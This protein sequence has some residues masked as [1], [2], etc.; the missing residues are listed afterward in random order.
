MPQGLRQS[1]W[2]EI[3]TPVDLGVIK[4]FAGG[5]K[6]L[7]RM[8]VTEFA[9]S[10]RILPTE[11]SEGGRYR[12]G[13][14][15][16]MREIMDVLSPSDPTNLVVFMKPGQV[17][18][19]EGG[20]NWIGY[21]I[22]HAPGRILQV[23]PTELLAK[24]HNHTRIRPLLERTPCLRELVSKKRSRDSANTILYKEFTGGALVLAGAN[25]ASGLRSIAAQY[26]MLDEIDGYPV[27][28]DNEGDP[29]ALA[30][31]RGE[32][33]TF[34]RKGFYL[35]TPT[36]ELTSR[37]HPLYQASDRR[38]FF[39]PCPYCQHSQV[40]MWAQ[41]RWPKNEPYNAWYECE[42]CGGQWQDWQRIAATQKG[43][44]RAERERLEGMAAGFWINAIY[45]HWV[46][47]GQMA[48]RFVKVKD[49][50]VQLK[51]FVNTEL[52][53]VWNERLAMKL[54]DPKKLILRCEDYGAQVPEGVNILTIGI[55]V[56]DD[57][58]EME[59][60]GW[61]VKEESWSITYHVLMGDPSGPAI[62]EDLD[63]YL[64]QAFTNNEGR[65]YM[66]QAGCIDTGGHHTNSVYA[67]C[68]RSYRRRIWAT[69]GASDQQ[70]PIWPR[71]PSR[72]N[73]GKVDLYIVNTNAVKA[74]VYSRL[75]AE[76]PGPG[77]MHFPL[78]YEQ[79]YFDM[80]TAE[81]PVP[82]YRAGRV[83]IEWKLKAHVRNEALDCRVL[84]Y[85]ATQGLGAAGFK[86]RVPGPPTQE[87]VRTV[88]QQD[89]FGRT[90]EQDERPA[91][92]I[93]DVRRR[94]TRS[95]HI[96]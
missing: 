51:T 32:T 64:D 96:G 23:Q 18:A 24:R 55:D 56:Q 43:E 21:I 82:R 34:R 76:P 86:M 48:T 44:W 7:T 70:A 89:V 11:E 22:R 84:A 4:A 25:S 60:V 78:G 58:L 67:Y 52:A 71:R 54:T 83:K 13:R 2:P 15:P 94:F 39:V 29:I 65:K 80:L 6:P 90:A 3:E 35:S 19:T 46:K 93:R 49:D 81:T 63:A 5:L 59:V 88:P 61:G 50:D 41:V 12:V 66:I 75:K 77:T 26:L 33:F 38:K 62:W 91:R 8:T 20:N 68:K 17:G 95:P 14:V 69:K 53:E 57:R 87:P 85:L 10:E 28:L 73:K 36:D 37:I 16:W 27:D 79:A 31:K 30:E 92:R 72:N 1:H 40:L 9:E 74:Q 42:A 47:L 45:S